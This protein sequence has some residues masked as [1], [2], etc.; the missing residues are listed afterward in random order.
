MPTLYI[1]IYI[2]YVNQLISLRLRL[3]SVAVA[4]MLLYTAA[5]TY[6]YGYVAI[7]TSIYM[8]KQLSMQWLLESLWRSTCDTG[9]HGSC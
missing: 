9:N 2:N 8:M 6:T 1:Y 3:L 5:W 4:N 7:L